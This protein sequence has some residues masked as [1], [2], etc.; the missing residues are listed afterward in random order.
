MPRHE[1]Q[2]TG[3]I[4]HFFLVRCCKP[5]HQIF[6]TGYAFVLLACFL[7]RT[8]E[9]L[10]VSIKVR[11]AEVSHAV[12]SRICITVIPILSWWLDNSVFGRLDLI[13]TPP[14]EQ[15]AGIDNNSMLDRGRSDPS[16]LWGLYF[17]PTS[18]VLK[19]KSDASIVRMFTSS[20]LVRVVL[21]NT[22]QH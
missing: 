20:D 17:K 21:E 4:Q 19:Q 14:A 5:L 6:P 7:P 10:D 3:L 22:L 8:W 11:V 1:R 15:I 13:I 9:S 16:P 18:V 12:P 2:I